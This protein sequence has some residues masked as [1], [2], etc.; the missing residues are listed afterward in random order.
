M[1]NNRKPRKR[2]K[3][4]VP[5]L[6][7]HMALFTGKELKRATAPILASVADRIYALSEPRTRV[8]L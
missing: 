6:A 5:G 4:P 2:S 3:Q 1:N 7:E 8:R